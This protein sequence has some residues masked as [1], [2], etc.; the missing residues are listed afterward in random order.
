MTNSISWNSDS[1]FDI[2]ENILGKQILY[3]SIFYFL[4]IVLNAIFIPIVRLQDYLSGFVVKTG[5]SSG[6]L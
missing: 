5:K 4:D 2:V 6:K 1:G 3:T